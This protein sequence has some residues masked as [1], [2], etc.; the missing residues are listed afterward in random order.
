MKS[1]FNFRTER[2][3]YSRTRLYNLVERGNE[4][5]FQYKRKGPTTFGRTSVNE[6]LRSTKFM[7]AIRSNSPHPQLVVECMHEDL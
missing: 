4:I 2:R 5:L 7:S 1:Y 3:L 6:L